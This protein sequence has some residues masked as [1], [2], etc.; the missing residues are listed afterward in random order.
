MDSNTKLLLTCEHASNHVPS[1]WRDLVR[2]PDD[3]LQSHR[4]YDPGAS[5]LT[6]I[7]RDSLNPFAT[8]KGIATRLLIDLN[9]SPHNHR[10]FS[11]WSVKLP[12]AARNSLERQLHQPYWEQA[13]AMVRSNLPC[14]HISVHSFT[15]N[16]NGHRRSTDIGILYNTQ[17]APSAA[18]GRQL[19]AALRQLHPGWKIHRN[20]PYSGNTDGLVHHLSKQHGAHYVGIEIELNQSLIE[21]IETI[22]TKL[23]SAVLRCRKHLQ[24]LRSGIDS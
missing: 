17:H 22:G 21:D 11:Q 9:R 14:L 4:G 18:F 10:R 23:A 7:L 15:P 6:D 20:Q 2:I 8:L 19:S 1:D 3:V 5:A 16:W 24:P 12:Y 13:E